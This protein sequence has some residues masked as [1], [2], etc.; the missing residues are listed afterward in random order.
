MRIFQLTDEAMAQA[1]AQ[2]RSGKTLQQIA[3]DMQISMEMAA[4]AVR[5]WPMIERMK[6]THAY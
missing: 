1:A 3:N 2:A 5:Q 4:S 6:L